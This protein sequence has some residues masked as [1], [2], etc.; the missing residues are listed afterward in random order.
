MRTVLVLA[1]ALA[2]SSCV[3]TSTGRK[4]KCFGANGTDGSFVQQP[5][6]Y[7]PQEKGTVFDDCVFQAF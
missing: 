5:L 1:V 7:G 6:A 2:L 3:G 4:S